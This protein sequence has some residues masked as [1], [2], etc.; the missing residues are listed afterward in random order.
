M[1]PPARPRLLP[2]SS[3]EGKPCYL[4]SEGDG[5]V[6][7]QADAVER[8]QLASAEILLGHARALLRED[9]ATSPEV[10]FLAGCLTGAL[11][12]TLRIS[13]SRGDRLGCG[14][15]EPAEA[16]L[17]WPLAAFRTVDD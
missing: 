8:T 9:G 13:R 7:R 3:P 6:T 16:E 11:G 1:T 15:P 5:P 2:W 14:H 4:L 17:S 10:R 12:D